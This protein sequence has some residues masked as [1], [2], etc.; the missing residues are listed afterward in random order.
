MLSAPHIATSKRNQLP[1]CNQGTVCH[2]CDC[3]RSPHP[4]VAGGG[5]APSSRGGRRWWR[6]Q[7]LTLQPKVKSVV[8][9]VLVLAA[10]VQRWQEMVAVADPKAAGAAA[11]AIAKLASGDF[12]S[13]DAMAASAAAATMA[14]TNSKTSGWGADGAIAASAAA[15]TMTATNS[16]ASG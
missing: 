6:W 10:L 8:T 7:S 5:H 15:A 13:N 4:P 2:P 11:V 1:Q 16:K 3:T 12:G 9:P 14:A